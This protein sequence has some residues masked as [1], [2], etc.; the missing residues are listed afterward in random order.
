MENRLIK[1]MMLKIQKV[2]KVKELIN[3]KNKQKMFNNHQIIN[4]NIK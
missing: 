1:M 4:D 3:N 2:V